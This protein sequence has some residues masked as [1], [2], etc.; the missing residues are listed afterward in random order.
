MVKRVSRMDDETVIV[1]PG[2]YMY[3]GAA[4][5]LPGV[6]ELLLSQSM[7]SFNLHKG[8]LTFCV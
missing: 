7:F 5:N 1:A 4:R 8:L 6:K 2:G 3:F